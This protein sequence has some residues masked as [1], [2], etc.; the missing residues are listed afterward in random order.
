MRCLTEGG[1]S[2]LVFELSEVIV[3]GCADLILSDCP[4]EYS[5]SNVDLCRLIKAKGN[6]F[7]L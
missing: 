7:L 6:N 1:T 4:Q 3:V 5:S 2:S